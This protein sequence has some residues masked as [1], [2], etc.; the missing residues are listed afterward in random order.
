MS[1]PAVRALKKGRPDL[2][3]TVL[4]PE[5]LADLW[6]EVAEVDRVVSIP[7]G[8]GIVKTAEL[9]RK[10]SF[11][12]AL[13]LPNSLRVALEAWWAGVPRLVGVPG[14]ARAFLLHQVVRLRSADENG[15]RHQVHHYLDLVRAIGAP[16][17]AEESPEMRE[18]LLARKSD[19]ETSPWPGGIE[20]GT[21]LEIAVC[22]GAEYGPAKRWFPDRF[23]AVMAEVSTRWECRWHLV[24]VARD[25]AVGQSVLRALPGEGSV[26]IED[27]VGRTSLRELIELLKRCDLLLTND[28]GTMHLAALLGVPVVAVFGSTEPRLTGPLGDG[29]AVVQHRV[30][31]GPCFLRE[32]PLDSAC[33][34]RVRSGEVVEAVEKVAL[35]RGKEKKVLPRRKSD[36]V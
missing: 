36:L 8:V 12:A 16:V 1:V 15:P 11:D 18:I 9:L 28:T 5:K 6:R 21:G 4:V 34:D 29:H 20:R 7:A 35:Q 22:P 10:W 32:C 17:S 23:A 31:C 3:L 27:W 19:R 26:K 33:M 13:L 24:G 25:V 30:P 14:H 2:E